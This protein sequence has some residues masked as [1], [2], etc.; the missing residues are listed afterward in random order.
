[1]TVSGVLDVKIVRGSVKGE[2]FID[3]IDND[4]LPHLNTF[5]GTNPNSVLVL[6]NCS[7][8]HVHGAVQSMQQNGSLIEF[9][10]PYSPDYNPIEFLFSKVKSTLRAM[11][12]ELSVTHDIETMVLMAFATITREDCRAWIDNIGLYN[13]YDD[14]T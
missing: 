14:G 10:P 4:L 12:T 9:L 11:E 6:D 5:N 2:D 1:M 8:H 7:V 13:A 3:Y